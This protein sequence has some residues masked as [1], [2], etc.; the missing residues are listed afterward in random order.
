MSA[1]SSCLAQSFFYNEH[2]NP[3]ESYIGPS[4]YT[5]SFENDFP[6]YGNHNGLI[7]VK[8]PPFS[9]TYSSFGPSTDNIEFGSTSYVNYPPTYEY[10]NSQPQQT[11]SSQSWPDSSYK[12]PL[13]ESTGNTESSYGEE[14]PISQHIE[15]TK[16]VVV[17]VY[18]KFPYAVPKKFPVAIPH[19]VLVPIPAYYPVNVQI[20]Q[21][22]ASPEIREIRI[23]IE[24]E[25]LYPVNKYI[26]VA[27]E[28]PLK[29]EV[30]KHFPVY[31]FKPY[32]VKVRLSNF[33]SSSSSSHFFS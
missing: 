31:V 14:T 17:P 8:N 18:K 12:E 25:V 22:V 23:P 26:P 24:R 28:K 2:Q 32:P 19:P 21:P 11:S 20:S 29:Y 9:S 15:I 1:C 7:N 4:S 13:Y 30:D 33:L 27:V 6:D 10:E 3:T 16:P 5:T